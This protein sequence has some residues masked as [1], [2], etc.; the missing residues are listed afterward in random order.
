MTG[1][2]ENKRFGFAILSAL[3]VWA[4]LAALGACSLIALAKPASASPLPQSP[5]ASA[6]RFQALSADRINAITA[7]LPP[8]PKGFG[9]TCAN[10]AVWSRLGQQVGAEKWISLATVE[11]A[12]PLTPWDDE[13]Y[14]EF[15]RI[16]ERG[17]GEAMMAARQARLERLVLGECLEG[18]G[19]FLGSISEAIGSI[20]QQPSWTLAA[21][22]PGLRNFKDANYTVDLNAAGVGE[23]IAQTLYMLGDGVDP[24]IQAQARAALKARVFD[25][26]QV[27]LRVGPEQNPGRN[28]WLTSHFNWNVVCL[29]GV[30]GA[31]LAGL[32]APAERAQFVAAAET[33]SRNFVLGMGED[34][35]SSEG[36]AYWGYGMSHFLEMRELV[37]QA[38]TGKLDLLEGPPRI[39]AFAAY[40]YQAQMPGGAVAPFGDAALDYRF[41]RYPLAYVNE[42]YRLGQPDRVSEL[43]IAS[44]T[45]LIAQLHVLFDKPSPAMDAR[46]G[47]LPSTLSDYFPVAGM[48]VSRA[49]SEGGLSISIKAGGNSMSHSH[50]DVG[51]YALAIG[52][53]FPAGDPGK[54]RYTAKTFGPERRT[55]KGIN[56]YGHPVPQVAGRLQIDGSLAHPKVLLKQTSRA[57]DRLLIDLKPAYDEPQLTS[58]TREM[59]H[60]RVGAGRV[61][62][63]DRFAFASPQTFE[64]AIITGEWRRLGPDTLEVWRGSK[65]VQVQIAASSPYE[66][67]EDR[68]DEEGIRFTRL[69]VRLKG[70]VKSGSV[71]VRYEL[72]PH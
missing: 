44:E 40:G 58:L 64:T 53:E 37:M 1:S 31:A 47:P 41:L 3:A 34:G 39:A 38:T 48:L 43:D 7:L 28:W 26:V 52:G 60:Q 14:L 10:R 21:H 36:P 72:P 45:R 70:N 18:Q 62:I 32:S 8:E 35:F 46:L 42:A 15:S 25:P 49:R 16:G 63:I 11:A 50:D 27:S 5:D 17:R 12:K 59:V 69:A 61:N 4:A 65:K 71:N 33:Y 20:V 29:D 68:V 66:I 24:Q 22:D 56:S 67:V 6:L 23:L 30:T 51:S 2:V 57:G 54:V 55:I 9:E 13:A 19:R